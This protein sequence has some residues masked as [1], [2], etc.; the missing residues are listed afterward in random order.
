MSVPYSTALR[1]SRK[2][3]PFEVTAGVTAWQTRSGGYFIDPIQRLAPD[4]THPS[5]TNNVSKADYKVLELL[6]DDVASFIERLVASHVTGLRKSA[7]YNRK[8]QK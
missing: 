3:P 2:D 4:A 6:H 1:H 8:Q 7:A 5:L